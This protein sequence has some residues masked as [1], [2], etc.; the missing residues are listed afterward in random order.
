MSHRGSLTLRT[1]SICLHV[2]RAGNWVPAETIILEHRSF[3]GAS[4]PSLQPALCT[5]CTESIHRRRI[6]PA[7]QL[8]G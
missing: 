2:L 8:V 7:A 5:A 1:C 6:Q 3:E 4:P